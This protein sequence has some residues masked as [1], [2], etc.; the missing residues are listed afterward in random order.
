M[1]E[2]IYK[3]KQR[4]MIISLFTENRHQCF[5]SKEII[6]ELKG[7]IGE[8]TVYRMLVKLSRE[9]ILQ[10]YISEDGKGSLYRLND[11]DRQENHAH[12]HLRCSNCGELVHMDCHM[13]E[14]ISQHLR[15]AHGFYIDN[16]KT[17]LYG[18]CEK[19][20]DR[21]ALL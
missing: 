16:A 5:S 13:M 4:S 11:C 12:F 9:G 10:K 3:T 17:V 2:Q 15:L 14:E 18:K 7:K 8:A 20:A 6:E 21:G 1:A 19:C